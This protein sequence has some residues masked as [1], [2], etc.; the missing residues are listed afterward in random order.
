MTFEIDSMR[1]PI[2]Y[3]KPGTATFKFTDGAGGEVDD[4]TFDDWDEGK[5]L[6][7]SSYIPTFFVTPEDTT[8]GSTPVTYNMVIKPFSKVAKGAIIIVDIPPEL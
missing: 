4:G 7:S 5:D 6:Y 1:N 2:D 8:A 3:I